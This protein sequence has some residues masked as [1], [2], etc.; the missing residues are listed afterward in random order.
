MS[1]AQGM[2]GLGVTEPPGARA[3]FPRGAGRGVPPRLRVP[4]GRR[5]CP[6]DARVRL[7]ARAAALLAA[8][9]APAP[10]DGA[11]GAPRGGMGRR[12]ASRRLPRRRRA[13]RPGVGL[14]G[15]R[16]RTP[17]RRRRAARDAATMLD[18]LTSLMEALSGGAAPVPVRLAQLVERAGVGTPAGIRLRPGPDPRPV[19]RSLVGADEDALVAAFRGLIGRGWLM[20]NGRSL[21]V[22]WEAWQVSARHDAP[23]PP[24]ARSLRPGRAPVRLLVNNVD[25]RGRPWR[26]QGSQ[27]GWTG[28]ACDDLGDQPDDRRLGPGGEA[29][30]SPG[31][32]RP[33]PP[34]PA[35]DEERLRPPK[36]P[37]GKRADGPQGGSS[38]RSP[39]HHF[40]AQDDECPRHLEAGAL[41]PAPRPREPRTRSVRR[42]RRPRW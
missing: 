38:S 13:A 36:A 10:G 18:A 24:A 20:V 14:R 8:R 33:P 39:K 42:R 19:R 5:S 23:P 40:D 34:P 16:G 15:P 35:I 29:P 12:G 7:A 25:D 4:G 1:G 11:R 28:L 41:R 17:A 27:S 3:A 31:D 2:T 6:W 37:K 22:P 26:T 21:I 30:S 9:G 32:A